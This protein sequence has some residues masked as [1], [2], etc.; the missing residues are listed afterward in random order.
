MILMPAAR[1]L[2]ESLPSSEVVE[3]NHARSR[4]CAA[5]VPQHAI[6]LLDCSLWQAFT[7]LS[8]LCF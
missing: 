1:H 5:L 4:V 2:F 6:N 3:A 7:N 8:L